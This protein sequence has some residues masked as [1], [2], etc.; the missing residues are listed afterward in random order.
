VIGAP[1][2]GS[3]AARL[4]M[5]DEGLP[6]AAADDASILCQVVDE[7][8]LTN[9]LATNADVARWICCASTPTAVTLADALFG[10][11]Y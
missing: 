4:L 5:I 11:E 3:S 6:V 2:C 8:Y 1:T 7:C 10:A 9:I